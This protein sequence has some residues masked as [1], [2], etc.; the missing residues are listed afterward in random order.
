MTTSNTIFNHLS[1]TER[2]DIAIFNSMGLSISNIARKLHRSPSTIYRE[3]HRYKDTSLYRASLAQ[4]K[5]DIAKAKSRKHQKADNVT[6]L[7]SIEHML[8]KR[9]SPQIIVQK[10]GHIIS[11]TTI[12]TIIRTI[13][14]E[15]RKFL[16]YQ[17]KTKYHK[18]TA[19]KQLI[20][21][22]TDISDRPT[23]VMFGDWEADT[24][25]GSRAGNSCLAVYVE[26][27]SRYYKVI[28][29]CNKS[30][31]SMVKAT[32]QA[33]SKLRVNS[34]TYD[35]GT[36]N[37]EHWLINRLLGCASY[38]CRPY[39][40]WDKGL[41]EN[42]NK[43]LRQ[44]LP[45]GTNFDLISQEDIDKIVEEINNRPMKV[46]DWNTPAQVFALQLDL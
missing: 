33:L 16:I 30:S 17:R 6:L 4:H 32:L 43:I 26:R 3:L 19:G 11:H 28:K 13:R 27:K 36:E 38:F 10:L 22:R 44:Y 8:K 25:I 15:W 29:M 31:D 18:G 21:Y 1:I 39:R 9:W 12:Y 20:P 37:A 24:V 5:A 14:T 7:H 45:K 34:I 23:E 41:V 42:R 46:L 2:E 40:S 35:N